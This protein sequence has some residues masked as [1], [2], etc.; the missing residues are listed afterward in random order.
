MEEQNSAECC[1]MEPPPEEKK[2]GRERDA[3]ERDKGKGRKKEREGG[4]KLLSQYGEEG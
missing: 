3:S 4:E 2:G 1:R